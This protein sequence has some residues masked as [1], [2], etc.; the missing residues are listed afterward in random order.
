V[1]SSTTG[2]VNIGE[3]PN[4]SPAISCISPNVYS[5]EKQNQKL[6]Y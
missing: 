6:T 2:L 4:S 3:S 1:V 5:L